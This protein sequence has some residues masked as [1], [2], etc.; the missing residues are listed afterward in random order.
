VGWVGRGIHIVASGPLTAP[1]V[2]K[3]WH[4]KN[5]LAADCS[6]LSGGVHHA[7]VSSLQGLQAAGDGW[8]SH[9]SAST[10]AVQRAGMLGELWCFARVPVLTLARHGVQAS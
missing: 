2:G 4:T 10:L 1:V 9:Y 7:S 5:T 6:L 3:L 8:R